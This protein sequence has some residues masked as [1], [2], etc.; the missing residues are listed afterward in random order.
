MGTAGAAHEELAALLRR[1]GDEGCLNLAEVADVAQELGMGEAEVEDLYARIE[2]LG[3]ELS[4]DCGREADGPA[5]YANGALAESTTDAL[6]LFMREARRTPL[7]TAEE[8]I[9]LAKR[10]EAGDRAARE[11]MITANLR[12]VISIAR[13]YQNRNMALLDL[14]QEGVLG[15]MRAVEKFDWRRGYK[16]STYATWWIRQAVQRGIANQARTIRLP[17]HVVEHQMRIAKNE[18]RL[19]VRLGRDPTDAEIAE[20]SRLPVDRVAEIREASRTIT[21]LDRPIGEEGDAAFGDLLPAEGDDPWRE[22]EIGTE[23]SVLRAALDELPERDRRVLALRYGLEGEPVSLAEVGKRLGISRER[24]RQLER[25]ALER[26]ATVRELA[27]L[28]DAA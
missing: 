17:V 28:R 20:A 11:Q 26:L 7:L 1:G 16:F 13:R 8:E 14:I 3:I 19:R 15:L 9:A 5:V 27:A 24:A 18:N 2:E 6:Q 21:S 10:I 25:Q 22:L 12:L 4:D 23:E